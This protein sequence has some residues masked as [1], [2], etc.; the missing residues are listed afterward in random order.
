MIRR[1][2]KST[3]FPYTTLFG[4]LRREVGTRRIDRAGRVGADDLDRRP[5][6]LQRAADARDGAA[7][8]HTRQIGRAHVELQS[9]QYLVC[10]L[11]LEKKKA[12]YFLNIST[13]STRV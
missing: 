5:M 2:P 9:R 10:R 7:G 3:L 13:A 1:H 4:P 6:V 12:N 11:L 8:A